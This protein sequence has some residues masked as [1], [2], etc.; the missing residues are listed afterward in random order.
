MSG[1]NELYDLL[2]AD[3][4]LAGIV[5]ERIY[6]GWLPESDANSVGA[7]FPC[8]VYRQVSL[9]PDEMT[10]LGNDGWERTRFA[11]DCW[12][13]PDESASA[14]AIAHALADVVKSVLRTASCRVES[15]VDLPEP[16]TRLHRVVV[17]AVLWTLTDTLE[18]VPGSGS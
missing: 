12:A 3:E 7:Q 11:F 13:A 15:E 4:A 16:Q 2:A 5:D 8:V 9:E 10:Q 14:Y 17:D 1:V 6:A 18:Y